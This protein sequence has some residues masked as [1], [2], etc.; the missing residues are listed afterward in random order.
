MEKLQQMIVAFSKP[1]YT[2]NYRY[3][4]ATCT[5][6]MCGE[7]ARVFRD[8][9]AKVEYEISALCQRCQDECLKGDQ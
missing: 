5:C 4:K 8:E 9:W 6:L 2:A 7:A 3:A 1:A